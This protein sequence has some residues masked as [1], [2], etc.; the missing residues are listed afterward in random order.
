MA[1][2]S[3]EKKETGSIPLEYS[4]KFVIPTKAKTM[5]INFAGLGCLQTRFF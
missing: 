5:G 4:E 2:R 3:G 1:G